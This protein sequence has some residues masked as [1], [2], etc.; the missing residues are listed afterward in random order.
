[1]LC[2]DLKHRPPMQKT[3]LNRLLLSIHGIRTR[4]EWQDEITSK[5]STAGWKHEPWKY[6]YF[7]L[8][9][10][11]LERSRKAVMESFHEWYLEKCI[12]FEPDED[13]RKLFRPS[14]VAH[15]FGS[16][17]LGESMQKY[18]EIKFDKIIL[19]GSILPKDFDWP[20]LLGRNQV[21][22]V[23][24]EFG[25]R[26]K[27]ASMTGRF[28]PRTGSSGLSGFDYQSECIQPERFEYHEHSD[29]FKPGHC[30]TNWI[31]FLANESLVVEILHGRE[32]DDEKEFLRLLNRSHEIDTECFSSSPGYAQAEVPR[33]L[34]S[35]WIA[36]NP[37]IYTFLIDIIG[38][39]VIGYVNA[40]PLRR[41]VF[42][43]VVA[44]RLDDNEITADDIASFESGD[45]LSLY[46][47]SIAT[48][49]GAR[50]PGQGIY[51]D[52][53][54]RLLAGVENKVID[55]WHRFG[56]RV[57]EIGAV[58][59]TPQGRSLCEALKLPIRGKDKHGNPT[60]CMTVSNAERR[61]GKFAGLV[62]R[63]KQTY[64]TP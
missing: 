15:S 25:L 43:N 9:Q 17:V 26:D 31:P 10:F 11:L 58:G 22:R 3:S 32:I 4:G 34:S 42:E 16:Y 33:G 57:V 28:V 41:E 23:K 55:Y 56:S 35:T 36:V 63:L 29:Y 39:R 44:G 40:M 54:E 13:K 47:M 18:R 19:C 14:I 53:F 38:N 5:L 37:D 6:G 27:W 64:E 61:R 30:E 50:H 24:N 21:W 48:E 49:P 8:R 51:Q 60:Y 20:E 59:W 12:E 45:A 7:S 62:Y 46:L 52:A 1:M 2:S